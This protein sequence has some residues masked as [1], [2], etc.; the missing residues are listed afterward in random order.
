[1]LLGGGSIFFAFQQMRPNGNPTKD[2]VLME[3]I[4]SNLRNNHFA[5]TDLNDAFSEKVYNLYLKRADNGKRIFLQSDVDGLKSFRYMLDDQAKSG[6]FTF[7]DSLNN[8][9]TRRFDQIKAIYQD[10][11]AKPFNL[12]EAE[13]IETEGDKL[14]YPKDEAELRERWRKH[15][16]YQVLLRVESKLEEQEKAKEKGD[17]TVTIKTVEE[18]EKEARERVLK[19]MNEWADGLKQEDREDRLAFYVETFVNVNEPHTG[20]FPPLEKQNFDIRMSGKLEGIGAQLRQED[21]YIK[22]VNIVP[23]SA[24]ARQGELQ[25]NDKIIKVG[26]GAE[27]PIDV[28][29]MKIDDVLPM[30]RG[31]KGTEVR[32]TVKKQDGTIKVIPI[33][34]DVVVLED[35]Y[36]KSAIIEHQKTKTKVGLIDLRSF[37]ADFEDA[38]GRRC[39]KDVRAEVQKLIAEGVD[40]IVIDLRFNGGG[41]L[42]DVVDM[43]GYFIEKGP[44]VQVKA[45]ESAPVLLEDRDASVLYSGPLVIVV[46]SFSASASEIMAAALQDYGRAI[47][48]G[49]APTTFGKGTVQRFFNL[50]AS[51]PTRYKDVGE[52][53]SLKITIQKFYRVNGGSTQLGGV[54]PDIILPGAYSYLKVGEQEE[55]YPMAW[56]KIEPAKYKTDESASKILDKIKKKSQKR[57]AA[58]ETFKLLDENGKWLKSQQDRS[59]YPLQLD[60]YTKMRKEDNAQAERFKAIE[61]DIDDLLIHS[62]AADAPT[63][64]ADTARA[65]NV[66]TW[67]KALKKDPYLEEIVQIIHDWK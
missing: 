1:M 26:Q 29:D 35:S 23:G 66:K 10:I 59:E 51:V 61:K 65:E 56:D 11:L 54:V 41:S 34:R 18:L 16:K 21:G 63:M 43:S 14:S 25:V 7:F 4:L 60:L 42:S 27:D 48:V 50:D 44:V 2:Q 67:H 24:S 30:I 37:Y 46:N 39:S 8:V 52:L 5:P 55:D 64:S 3:V 45:R 47:V 58:S 22:V 36:A 53:G 28:V 15:L 31:K 17:K 20:Y 40:G 13:T 9:Q 33:I 62:L 19:S 57:V 12:N 6:Q 38:N 49:T 32:L